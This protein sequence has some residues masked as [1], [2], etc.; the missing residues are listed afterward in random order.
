MSDLEKKSKKELLDIIDQL[1]SKL[2]E[3]REV[4]AK[5]DALE[6]NLLGTGFSVIRDRDGIFK[7]IEIR[8]DFD[9]KAATIT[10]VRELAT[11]GYDYAL[12]D[13]KKFLI[14]R[15]MSVDNINHLKE[16]KNG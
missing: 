12:Y 1:R 13:A 9:S 10:N 6:S 8:F 7:L 5:Q 4:E 2:G 15:I 16:T 11:N 14:E 3:V